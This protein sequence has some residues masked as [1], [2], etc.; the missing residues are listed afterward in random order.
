VQSDKQ[1]KALPH[2]EPGELLKSKYSPFLGL[3]WGILLAEDKKRAAEKL[4]TTRK[5]IKK[6]RVSLYRTLCREKD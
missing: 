1:K 2:R 3:L 6:G 4:P 5:G